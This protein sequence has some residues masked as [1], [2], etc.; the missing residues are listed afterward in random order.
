MS[1]FTT[2]A[3]SVSSPRSSGNTGMLPLR[4]LSRLRHPGGRIPT[5]PT[6]VSSNS[7]RVFALFPIHSSSFAPR[8]LSNLHIADFVL[9]KNS[10]Q[11][12][13]LQI[14]PKKPVLR[15]QHTNLQRWPTLKRIGSSLSDVQMLADSSDVSL[16]PELA[17]FAGSQIHVAVLIAMPG[18]TP[19]QINNCD[20]QF[21][22]PTSC[23]AHPEYSISYSPGSMKGSTSSP[24][25]YLSHPSSTHP[26][27]PRRILKKAEG[28][29][30]KGIDL[31]G[32]LFSF[33]RLPDPER[34]YQE[35]AQ[36]NQE[37]KVDRSS[38]SR[39]RD[40]FLLPFLVAG[41]ESLI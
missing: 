19:K 8:R 31:V 21:A 11:P 1:N 30:H 7:N 39:D 25:R 23:L 26:R 33:S 6:P 18:S 24:S 40:W 34:G 2:S 38:E 5:T 36:I 10:K 17:T 37:M 13:S 41:I 9:G 35:A 29:I 15:I 3:Q 14:L 16:D 32:L 27:L 28:Q 20:V 12:F 4:L 22:R